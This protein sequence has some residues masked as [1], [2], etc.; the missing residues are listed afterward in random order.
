MISNILNGKL[1]SSCQRKKLVSLEDCYKQ[2]K[3]YFKIKKSEQVNTSGYALKGKK[4]QGIRDQCSPN[5]IEQ[6]QII[7]AKLMTERLLKG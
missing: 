1:T 2:L 6:N 5:L 3:P 7:Y 4:N